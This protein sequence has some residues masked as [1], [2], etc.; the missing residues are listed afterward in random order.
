MPGVSKWNELPYIG[1][2]GSGGSAIVDVLELPTED[3]NEQC[4]YRLLTGTFISDGAPADG[5]TCYIVNVL[6][7]VG[8][9]VTLDRQSITAYYN[10]ISNTAWGYINDTLSGATGVP[11]GWYPLDALAEPFGVKYNGIIS[12]L[13]DATDYEA[14]YL[15]IENELYSYNGEWESL[16]NSIGYIGTGYG[17]EIFNTL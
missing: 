10:V 9:P 14:I 17:A 6:P 5:W 2:E 3:I 4:F 1:G 13:S 12:S 11:A 16:S 8:E 7:E 15:L